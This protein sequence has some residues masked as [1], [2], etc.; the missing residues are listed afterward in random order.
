MAYRSYFLFMVFLFLYCVSSVF[1]SS[2]SYRNQSITTLKP[3]NVK[4]DG[5]CLFNSVCLALSG[6][7]SR[8]CEL[9]VRTCIFMRNHPEI[10]NI[11]QLRK[12]F[13]KTLSEKDLAM[14]IHSS[15]DQHDFVEGE[16]FKTIQNHSRSM[17]EPSK[18]ASMIDI[19]FISQLLNI[20]IEVIYPSKSNSFTRQELFS[21]TMKPSGAPSR[22]IFIS[23]TSTDHSSVQQLATGR[24]RPNHF[25]PCIKIMAPGKDIMVGRS[26]CYCSFFLSYFIVPFVKMVSV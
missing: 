4:K 11:K 5:S 12:L 1:N 17:L 25:V 22:K 3:I 23:W 6:S 7:E 21:G 15:V 9:R 20:E 24:W 10:F 18:Y 16:M 13:R 8:A 14:I 2:I 19:F 26:F